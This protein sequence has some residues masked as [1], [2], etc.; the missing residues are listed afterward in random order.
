MGLFGGVGSGNRFRRA[1]ATF[2][3]SRFSAFDLLFSDSRN[4]S[5]E[6]KS[7]MLGLSAPGFI[8]NE[9]LWVA[10]RPW[11]YES[12]KRG[13]VCI[14]IRWI[15]LEL[16]YLRGLNEHD[17]SLGIDD[18][19]SSSRQQ[20]SRVETVLVLPSGGAIN[21]FRESLDCLGK[22]LIGNEELRRPGAFSI[23]ASE[24]SLDLLEINRV[25]RSFPKEL[26]SSSVQL[27]CTD[28]GC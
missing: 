16:M 24:R 9:L 4:R 20:C 21:R 19:N 27:A 1:V 5:A 15:D 7:A 18:C 8:L 22:F 17:S 13:R 10:R 6:S 12:N 26:Q 3:V 11:A 25:T 23:L 14:D 28:D 2:R